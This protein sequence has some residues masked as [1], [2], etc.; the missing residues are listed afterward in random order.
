MLACA[1]AHNNKPLPCLTA[2]AVAKHT[3]TGLKVAMK[4]ISKRKIST[5]EMSNR[6]H[7]EVR[8]RRRLLSCWHWITVRGDAV[9]LYG[10]QESYSHSSYCFCDYRFSTSVCYGILTSSSCAFPTLSPP[11]P[12][13]NTTPR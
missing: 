4:F 13:P 3:A 12:T 5:A 10:E 8:R 6:V 9:V 11:L 7:R 2:T 1:K